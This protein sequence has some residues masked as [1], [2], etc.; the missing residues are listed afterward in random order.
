MFVFF[1]KEIYLTSIF[2]SLKLGC[3]EVYHMLHR[4]NRLF[5]NFCDHVLIYNCKLH[6]IFFLGAKLLANV[7]VIV[8]P[9]GEM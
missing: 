6:T 1:K 5:F 9:I 3:I 8:P 2:F 7:R 4:G